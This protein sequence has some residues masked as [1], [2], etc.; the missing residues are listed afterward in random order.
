MLLGVADAAQFAPDP[1]RGAANL[2][3]GANPPPTGPGTGVLSPLIRGGVGLLIT[4]HMLT[5]DVLGDIGGDVAGGIALGRV[6]LFPVKAGFDVSEG[7]TPLDLAYQLLMIIGEGIALQGADHPPFVGWAHKEQHVPVRGTVVMWFAH[8]KAVD[9]GIGP[10]ERGPGQAPQLGQIGAGFPRRSP[11]IALVLYGLAVVL[12]CPGMKAGRG[13]P[14]EED[15]HMPLLFG[16]IFK[17]AHPHHHLVAAV[18][19]VGV[20][21]FP[22]ILHRDHQIILLVH[23]LRLGQP[24]HHSPLALAHHLHGCVRHIR[25]HSLAHL[26]EHNVDVLLQSVPGAVDALFPPLGREQAHHHTQDPV[27]THL[28]GFEFG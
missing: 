10:L 13:R 23:H 28:L 9:G 25:R 27:I 3:E 19:W 15:P 12:L 6:Y 20:A 22:A 14:G 11:F 7:R 16:V 21:G 18:D 26:A 2:L 8:P 24:A 4:I 17:A 1:D 5:V